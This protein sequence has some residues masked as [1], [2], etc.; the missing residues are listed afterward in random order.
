[1]IA[2]VLESMNNSG[3]RP[4]VIAWIGGFMATPHTLNLG[5]T[6]PAEKIYEKSA[7]VD[8]EFSQ[9]R[10]LIEVTRSDVRR[11]RMQVEQQQNDYES[12]AR[13]TMVLSIILG[14]LIVV[15]G[16]TIW[17]AYPTLKDH[18]SAMTKVLGLQN[19]ATGL[20][21]RINSAEIAINKNSAGLP[22]LGV[23][24]DQLKT[25]MSTGL[26]TARNQAQAVAT[27]MGERIR[28]DVNRSIQVIQSRL[29]GVEAN[30]REASEHVAQLEGRVAGL[31]QELAA[32][33]EEASAANERIKQ[34]DVAQQAS[35]RE[36][37]GLN[38]QMVS[39]RG[40]LGALTN[41]LD[42]K[43]IEFAA[44]NKRSTQ[45]TPDIQ[46]T[47]GSVNA[48]RQEVNGTLLIGTEAKKLNIRGQAV[49]QP[50]RFYTPGE[51]RA[52]ELV[53]TQV[54]KTSVSGY[55]I[56]PTALTTAEQ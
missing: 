33:R 11:M 36:M 30:Q 37:S 29:S 2:V 12:H 26:R 47:V 17:A 45:I 4:A 34:L 5:Q 6:P 3:R 8:D 28:E 56:V 22:A 51:S 53:F 42:R 1:M 49:Q 44:P 19:V 43:R 15:F 13:R 14:I 41:Q 35:S 21:E 46:F 9:T 27:Q 55:L 52:I 25:N 48:G 18:G 39:S 23:Q 31:T 16:G 20:G 40:A 50:I 10:D 24:V 32:V 38:Q 7:V 54:T